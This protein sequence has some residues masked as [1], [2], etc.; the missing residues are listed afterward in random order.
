MIRVLAVAPDDVAKTATVLAHFVSKIFS[1]GSGG[2]NPQKMLQTAINGNSVMWVI[3]EDKT[4][5]G[6]AFTGVEEWMEGRR[7]RII[8]LAGNSMHKWLETFTEEMKRHGREEDCKIM[9]AEGRPGWGRALGLKPVR[10]V[11]EMET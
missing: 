3:A 2:T 1:R 7:L 5:L 11:I 10:H 4:P 6:V 9:V 8:G